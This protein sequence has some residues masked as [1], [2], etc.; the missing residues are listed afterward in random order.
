MKLVVIHYHLRP[1]GV[2][3]V[4][5]LATA[6]LAK[7]LS[8]TL[9]FVV[10]AVG[11]RPDSKWKSQFQTQLTGTPSEFFIEPAFNY[12]SE[13]HLATGQVRTRLRVA[14]K[15]LLHDAQDGNTVVWA[16]N[17]GI[18]RNLLLT[19]EV[20]RACA[21]RGIPLLLHH[22]D[23]WFDNRWRRWPEMRSAGFTNLNRVAR[24]IFASVN[25]TH[26]L[27]INRSDALQLRR[28]F[29]GNAHWVPNLIERAEAPPKKRVWATRAW[30]QELFNE[31]NAPVW[32]LP[33]RALRRKNMAE[34][35]LLTRW[36]RPE[37]WLVTTGG[38]SSADEQLYF[39]RLVAAAHENRWRLRLG[40]LRGDESKK[41]SVPELL[42]ASEAVLLTSIQEGFGLPYLEAAAAR[43][44]LIARS[45]PNIAPDLKQLGFR[46]PQY[47]EEILIDPRLFDWRA[48]QG[49][50]TNLF[51][52]WRKQLPRPVQAFAG[53][54]PFLAAGSKPRPVAFSRLTFTA[55][56]QVLSQSIELSWKLCT[57]LNP[58]L[59]TWRKRAQA[60]RLQLTAWPQ[61]A[62]EQLSGPAYAQRIVEIASQQ[63]KRRS[64]AG[65]GPAVQ[66]EFL[67]AKLDAKHL[68][69]LLWST[70]S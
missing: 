27:A 61:K 18:G 60:G 47:Y 12:L 55:Q 4:I 36:L 58:F 29:S 23:W 51:Q 65:A 13:Q 70:H 17:L 68:F 16:H 10:L 34:A 7:R 48:E 9:E 33:C 50:Q 14:L 40:I 64:N 63:S 30:L 6:Q 67:R 43:R 54:P 45:I 41:P 31:R 44:P 35:L 59:L 46:F 37:A 20:T 49:R 28:G 22:H 56:L 69:P 3:R 52:V 53:R 39:K 21:E 57:P 24:V 15:S 25:S 2:R 32:I 19:H 11:E 1:G 42:A 8:R 5:E 26:H 62:A 66:A 38:A